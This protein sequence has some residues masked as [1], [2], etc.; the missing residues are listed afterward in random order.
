M[1][2]LSRIGLTE[3]EI[4]GAKR[5]IARGILVPTTFQGF[6]DDDLVQIIKDELVALSG[7]TS[8]HITSHHRIIILINTSPCGYFNPSYSY[9]VRSGFHAIGL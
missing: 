7:K 4:R 9:D 2:R 5:L 6:R 3:E 1:E 8:H